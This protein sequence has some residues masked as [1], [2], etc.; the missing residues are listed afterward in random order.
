MRA[1]FFALLAFTCALSAQTATPASNSIVAYAYVGQSTTPGNI[2]AFAIRANGVISP[3]SGSTFSGP[4]QNLVVSSGYVFGTDQTNIATYTRLSNGALLLSSSVNG[5]AH[6]DT[7]SGSSVGPMTLDHTGSSLYVAERNFQGTDNAAYAEFF[8]IRGGKLVFGSNTPIDVDDGSSLQF[9]QD[10]KFAY[11]QG[12]YFASFYIPAFYREASG[13]LT[14]FD[15]G[16]TLPP[17][18]G[19]ETPCPDAS[20]VSAHE[21]LAIAYGNVGPPTNHSIEVFRITQS[22]ALQFISNLQTN[23]T[24]IVGIRFDPTGEYLAVAGQT[25]IETFRLNINGTLT[26]LS[27]PILNTTTLSSV[28]WDKAGHVYAISSGALYVFQT[29]NGIMSLA[30]QPVTV[31]QPQSLAVLP[32]Q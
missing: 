27:A 28:Q 24:G 11:G 21:Y 22:G 8:V 2:S 9:S 20:A 3:V 14:P 4:A 32:A 17:N 10:N 15:P 18:S 13:Q 31:A 19:N 5:V 1:V 29:H 7:P 25:G 12:C 16:I 26:L 30:G 6:N 23:F